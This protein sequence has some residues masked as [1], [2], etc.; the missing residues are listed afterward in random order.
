MMDNWEER[1]PPPF[2][3]LRQRNIMHKDLSPQ[4]LQKAIEQYMEKENMDPPP[5]PQVTIPASMSFQSSPVEFAQPVQEQLP[6]PKMELYPIEE[7]LADLLN[8]AVNNLNMKLE[9]P[10]NIFLQQVLRELYRLKAEVIKLAESINPVTQML[11]S[12]PEVQ[13]RKKQ[14]LFKKMEEDDKEENETPER[15]QRSRRSTKKTKRNAKK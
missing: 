7:D 6:S 9:T 15:V 14:L 13:P 4:Q 12:E 11:P 2:F 3:H 5:K 10:E 8:H 1:I